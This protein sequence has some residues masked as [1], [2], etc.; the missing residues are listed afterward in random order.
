MHDFF[1]KETGRSP[2]A[3]NYSVCLVCK[4]LVAH[5]AAGSRVAVGRSHSSLTASHTAA[6]SAAAAAH[7]GLGNRI[8]LLAVDDDRTAVVGRVAVIIEG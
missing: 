4:G 1:A 3:L 6:H 5:I 2:T 8:D 7:S